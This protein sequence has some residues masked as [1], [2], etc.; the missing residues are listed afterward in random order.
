MVMSSVR[1]INIKIEKC[2]PKT[3]YKKGNFLPPKKKRQN[4][5]KVN[6]THNNANRLRKLNLEISYY[7]AAHILEHWEIR[8]V[9]HTWLTYPVNSSYVLRKY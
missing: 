5:K 3:N 9:M 4:Q 8:E 6:F 1:T 7:I 2:S